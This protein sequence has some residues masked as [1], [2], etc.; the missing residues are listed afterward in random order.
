MMRWRA[1]RYVTMPAFVAAM[2]AS[3]AP[4]AA[5]AQGSCR[6]PGSRSASSGSWS[7][8]LDRLVTLDG[9]A[10]TLREA[11]DRVTRASGVRLSYSAE[12]LPLERSVCAT[13]RDVA[14]GQVLADLLLGVAVRPAIVS[15]TQVVLVPQGPPSQSAPTHARTARAPIGVLD[16]IVVTGSVAGAEQRS[17]AVDVGV[18]DGE[19]LAGRGEGNL[20]HVTNG[21]VPGIWAWE[22]APSSMASRYGSIRGTSS[23]GVNAPKI[24]IDGIAVAN[25]LLVTQLVPESVDR[26]EVIRGPQGSALYGADAIGGVVNIVT[27][28]DAATGGISRLQL[29]SAIGV[30]GSDYVPSGVLARDM[31]AS[32]RGGSSVTSTGLSLAYR[33]IGEFLPRANA[34]DVLANA[35]FRKVGAR[36]AFVATARF[37]ARDAGSARPYLPGLGAGTGGQPSAG[38]GATGPGGTERWSAGAA[39]VGTDTG[40]STAVREYTFGLTG[41]MAQN[42]RWTHTLVAGV[43][44]YSLTGSLAGAFPVV[45]A[46]DSALRDARGEA[47]RVTLRASSVGLFGMGTSIAHTLTVAAEQTLT[48]QETGAQEFVYIPRM[49]PGRDSLYRVRAIEWRRTSGLVGQLNTSFGRS[50]FLTAGLRFE[51]SAG[52]FGESRVDAQPMLG[53]STVREIGPVALK[54]RTAYGRGIRVA[55]LTVRQRALF[56]LGRLALPFELSPETQSGIE[57][58]VDAYLGQTMAV[59][60]TRFDQQASGLVQTVAV[61]HTS[62]ATDTPASRIAYELQNVGRIANRGWEFSARANRGS[63]SVGGALTLVDSRVLQLAASYAGDLRAGDRPL[64]V[65]SRTMSLSAA[66]NGSRWSGSIVVARAADWVNYDRVALAQALA[67]PAPHT[68]ISG[69]SLR[70]YWQTYDGANRVRATFSRD[71][72]RSLSFVAYGENLLD[73]QRGEPDNVTIVPGRTITAGLRI[74][75]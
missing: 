63:L 58:G 27:R 11:L 72:F 33:S 39:R 46:S 55:E 5:A 43:D 44:A 26:V 31:V 45:T 24:Y 6:P 41:Q 71:L 2:A 35:D 74:R 61:S 73:T 19:R 32:L 15:Q 36:S 30:A 64:E 4:P 57:T 54:F 66:W 51:G 25:P 23:F 3:M 8:P 18:V 59:H 42:E 9:G 48:R 56:A 38:R 21:D 70:D 67:A 10:E 22:S 52:A 62:Q 69:P 16:R 13:F 65:P 40:A 7:S 14:L 37:F 53:L 68:R 50:L 12:S 60:V 47:A 20:A 34:S 28:H 49:A 75:M 29:R 1:N 17:L